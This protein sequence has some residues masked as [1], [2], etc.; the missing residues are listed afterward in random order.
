MLFAIKISGI[1][2]LPILLV[3]LCALFLWGIVV[4][5]SLKS[6]RDRM[7]GY[8]QQVGRLAFERVQ[9]LNKLGDMLGASLIN[10]TEGY[11][12]TRLKAETE[13]IESEM[14]LRGNPSPAATELKNKLAENA[15]RL[16][17]NRQKFRT[18]RESY[19]SLCREMPYRLIANV[20]KFKPSAFS[21]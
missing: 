18:A 3:I 12:E 2:V 9:L 19:N 10:D 4:Y 8:L 21:V 17:Q 7:E 11:D 15:S 5:N 13:K 14:A 20:F 1:G 16:L 6:R